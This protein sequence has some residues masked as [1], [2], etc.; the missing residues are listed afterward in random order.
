MMVRFTT[1]TPL[2]NIILFRAG[3]TRPLKS[4]RA[5]HEEHK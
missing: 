2:L 4:K 5:M 3:L 1:H